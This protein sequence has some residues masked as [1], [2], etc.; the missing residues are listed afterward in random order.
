SS[1]GSWRCAARLGSWSVWRR[2]RAGALARQWRTS[3]ITFPDIH[4]VL[5][6]VHHA[7]CG[8]GVLEFYGLVQAAQSEPLDR[9]FLVAMVADG[10]LAPGDLKRFNHES[11]R[12]IASRRSRAPVGSCR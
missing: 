12:A 2:G 3:G 1:P 6:L 9:V 11:P 8:R 7:A 4:K 5:H 10:A